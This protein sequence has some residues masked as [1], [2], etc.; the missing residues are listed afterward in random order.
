MNPDKKK[1]RKFKPNV[2]KG[3][4][5]APTT[6]PPQLEPEMKVTL[7][8]SNSTVRSKK[9]KEKTKKEL[10]KMVQVKGLYTA[11]IE[12]GGRH[13]RTS[14]GSSEQSAF[15]QSKAPVIKKTEFKT[16]G[17]EELKVELEETE[18]VLLDLHDDNLT[19]FDIT[20][21]TSEPDL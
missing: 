8:D 14:W 4:K 2:A 7:L 13:A 1:K 5:E 19:D 21:L 6:A 17:K 3:G 12:K 9:K 20:H 10:P 11:G 18:K 16:P 15:I